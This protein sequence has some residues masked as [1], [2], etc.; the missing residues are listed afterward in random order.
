MLRDD[1]RQ[2]ADVDLEDVRCRMAWHANAAFVTARREH[3]RLCR[4]LASHFPG[5]LILDVGTYLGASALSLSLP[6]HGNTVVSFDVVDH[7]PPPPTVCARDA[8]PDIELRI[9]DVTDEDNRG[10]LPALLADARGVPIVMLDVNHDG[11]AEREVYRILCEST[12]RFRG[13]LVVDD[14]H[15]NDAMRAFWSD[16]ISSDHKKL[17][18]TRFGH[19]SGTGIV[20]FDPSHIDVRVPAIP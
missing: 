1:R 5:A 17:D 9:Q 7:M 19:W 12:P 14:I 3:Y 11:V 6:N 16:D 8:A 13:L 20:V 4:F 10:V 18:V 2:I 15:L